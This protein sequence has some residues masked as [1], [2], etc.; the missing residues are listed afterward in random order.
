MQLTTE[1]FSVFFRLGKRKMWV[2]ETEFEFSSVYKYGF[3]LSLKTKRAKAFM[4]LSFS[5]CE[6]EEKNSFYR[7]KQQKVTNGLS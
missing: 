6:K 5:V 4:E 2:F 3:R 1:S 7:N